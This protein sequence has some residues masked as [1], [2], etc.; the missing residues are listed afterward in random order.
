M[1][2]EIASIANSAIA[3]LNRLD[4]SPP[5]AEA[6]RFMIQ[7]IGAIADLGIKASNPGAA[8][9]IGSAADWLG[10]T[11]YLLQGEEASERLHVAPL[12]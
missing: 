12:A 2:D 6:V 5:E 4:D 11:N 7:A 3:A 8:Q 9:V 1:F 10:L